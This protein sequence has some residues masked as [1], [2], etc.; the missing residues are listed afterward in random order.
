M[1]LIGTLLDDPASLACESF[2]VRFASTFS[3]IL[4]QY[5]LGFDLTLRVRVGV[6]ECHQGV[7][8]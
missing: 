5:L 4:Q 2:E 1:S 7:S 6:L 8:K 3:H